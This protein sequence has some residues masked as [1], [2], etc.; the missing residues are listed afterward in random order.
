MGNHQDILSY[1]P[2]RSISFLANVAGLAPPPVLHGRNCTL[3]TPNGSG[4][5]PPKSALQGLL[6]QHGPQS[7][8]RGTFLSIAQLERSSTLQVVPDH[9]V[10]MVARGSSRNPARP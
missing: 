3:G 1:I 10:A 9:A 6:A 4:R 8:A 2:R 7:Q 5:S